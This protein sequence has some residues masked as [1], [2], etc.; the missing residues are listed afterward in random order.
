[1]NTLRELDAEIAEKIF[2]WLWVVNRHDTLPPTRLLSHQNYN[3][4]TYDV[5]LG[6]EERAIGWHMGAPNYSTSLSEAWKLIDWMH[7][8]SFNV[9]VTLVEYSPLYT[10]RVTSR[11]FSDEISHATLATAISRIALRVWQASR[12]IPMR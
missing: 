11:A 1:M 4:D 9:F 2:G 8:L 12:K 3:R 10:V 5:A 6:D 7:S